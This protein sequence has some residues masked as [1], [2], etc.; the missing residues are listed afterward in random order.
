MEGVKD[1][2]EWIE[3]FE[4][5]EIIY[6]ATYESQ[7]GK[8]LQV[9]PINKLNAE[10]VVKV[11]QDTALAILEGKISFNKCFINLV[12]N[13]LEIAEV[14]NIRK[15]DDVLHRIIEHTKESLGSSVTVHGEEYQK[16]PDIIV[17]PN[18]KN[19]ELTIELSEEMNGSY[20]L[21]KNIPVAK[22]QIVWSGDTDMSF[23]ITDYNDP[24]VIYEKLS[25]K[26][27]NLLGK[28]KVF[29]DIEYPEGRYS[30]YTKRIFTNYVVVIDESD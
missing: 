30:I 22:R 3:N 17:T 27:D 20:K 19:K 13:K 26:I 10:N 9:G 12:S 21:G 15:V 4:M 5:P 25:C 23:L 1:F 24:H 11:D 7:S 8:I 28:S 16:S 18:R 6:G 29:R 14:K 2:D